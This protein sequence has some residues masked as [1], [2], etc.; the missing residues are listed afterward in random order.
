MLS[1]YRAAYA[2][3][4]ALAFAAAGFVARFAIAI[5]PIGLVLIISARTHTYGFAG[6]VSGCYV[7]GGAVGGP[8]GGRLVD[9]FGQGS[10]L[11]RFA[12]GHVAFAACLGLLI[13]VRAPLWTLL[14][15][16]IGMGVSFLS[17][18]ALI[19]AR[20]SY[21]WADEPV[22]R[23]TAYSIESA[24]DELVFVL[25]PLVATLLATHLPGLVTLGVAVALILLGSGWLAA[26][27]STEPP[28]QP[29][30]HGDR[31]QFVLSVQGM[32]LITW[33]MACTG[34]V[35]GGAEVT[36]VAFC[37]QHGQRG[38]SGWVIACFAAGSMV[39]GIGYGARN[40]RTP[41]LRRFVGSAAVFGVLPLLY[42]AAGSVPS[43]AVY[44]F[45]IGLGIAPTL[46]G[47]FSLV[48]Q[49]V[50]ARSLTE[51]LTWVITGLS[52]GYGAGAALVGGIADRHGAHA[53]FLVPICCALAAAGFAMALAVRLRAP[54]R[55]AVVGV[56]P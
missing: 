11:V 9:R 35:F 15:P 52:V 44:T 37:G 38:N 10:M 6:V 4:G 56:A 45:F 22:P 20:W 54:A 24:L 42:L 14:P 51:G 23:S 28:V 39:A 47:C 3:P 7:F 41:L 19:R 5:Y 32:Q 46:I 48:D 18:G 16:A 36:M 43:L 2:R 21:V 30:Q 13:A 40:W 33:M 50:P 49:I 29:R 55:P 31:H 26:Q 25:G 27:R 34:A 53:A 8:I 17:V 1:R 12:L